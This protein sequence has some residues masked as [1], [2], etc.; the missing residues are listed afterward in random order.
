VDIAA[1]CDELKPKV[2][3]FVVE[4]GGKAEATDPTY[5]VAVDIAAQGDELKQQLAIVCSTVVPEWYPDLC[6]GPAVPY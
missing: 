2:L 3:D 1:Q 4:N 6:S 5:D